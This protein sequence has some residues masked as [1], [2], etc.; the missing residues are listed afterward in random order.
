LA[1]AKDGDTHHFEFLRAMPMATAQA[2]RIPVS[3]NSAETA[4]KTEYACLVE[5]R[6]NQAA[7]ITAM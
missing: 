5:V 7:A 2:F 3:S 6:P 1:F 4:R